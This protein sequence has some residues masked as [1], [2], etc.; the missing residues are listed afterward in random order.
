M[1]TINNINLSILDNND[2]EYGFNYSFSKGLNIITG[3]NASGKS[4]ILTCIYYAF[5]MEQLYGGYNEKA[6]PI[7]LLEKFKY[8]GKDVNVRNAK[9]LLTITN[10]KKQT[11]S[12]KRII[13]SQYNEQ[14]NQI[15]IVENEQ[16]QTKFL[17]SEG[18]SNQE[19]GFYFWLSKFVGIDI[20][21]FEGK[22]ILYLQHIF[23]TTLIEQTKGWSDFFALLPYFDTKKAKQKIIE[24]SLDLGNLINESKIE[25]KK[26]E[27]KNEN[28]NWKFEIENFKNYVSSFNFNIPI[29]DSYNPTLT[30]DKIE[31]EHLFIE[32]SENQ[33]HNIEEVLREK[34]KK[35]E[36]LVLQN[37]NIK[38]INQNPVLLIRKAQIEIKLNELIN[39]LQKV[40]NEKFNEEEKIKHYEIIKKEKENEVNALD[41]AKKTDKLVSIDKVNH[42]PLCNS[43][44]NQ[45]SNFKNITTINQEQSI[46]F[47]KAEIKLYNSYIENSE[48]L[49]SRFD[50][51]I[52]HFILQIDNQRLLL[53][54]INNELIEDY[55]LPSK[56][57]LL[58]EI[59]FKNELSK[60]EFIQKRTIEFKYKLK[61]LSKKISTL[62]GDI[63]D[64][65]KEI[66]ND[67]N[68]INE[69][70]T[71]FIELLKSF[72]YTSNETY[73]ITLN[74]DE[75]YKYLPVVFIDNNKMPIRNVS[76]A[77]DFIRSMWA[78]YIAL[79]EK[80]KNHFGFLI[81]DEPGQHAMDRVDFK[82][83]LKSSSK[84]ETK[85]IICAVSKTSR[86][87]DKKAEYPLTDLLEELKIKYK[88]QE[89]EDN[90]KEDKCIQ[91][92]KK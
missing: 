64:L 32:V 84:F 57:K 28:D 86:D 92:I 12:L 75:T 52:N 14:K 89:I 83:L 48:K 42:C 67:K 88:L 13:K 5:G 79:L 78:Y 43:N 60:L 53:D 31:K 33:Y 61:T 11:V 37:S 24:Y 2:V 77:S 3:S 1:V 44:L 71:R 73:N 76:A 25:Q 20:P 59:Q 23:A 4:T 62:K 19:G 9:V 65:K 50:K 91:K 36:E 63:D 27:M 45:N 21:E 29:P 85:Q 56:S 55:R 49:Q 72:H 40:K 39:N 6:L 82:E 18:D 68:Q 87:K 17:H 46:S 47:Y 80:A 70:Q 51:I 30:P 66:N 15:F 69:F 10:E 54:E 8:N 35:Y 41:N 34:Q 16:E 38:Q 81:L 90:G 26:D 74:T 7:S 22:K 58:E